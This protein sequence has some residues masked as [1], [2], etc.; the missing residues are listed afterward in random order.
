ME[1]TNLFNYDLNK[2][3]IFFSN[4]NNV[5]YIFDEKDLQK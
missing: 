5:D 3:D 4:N 1:K 2:N